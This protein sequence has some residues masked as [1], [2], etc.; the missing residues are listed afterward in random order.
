MRVRL[1]RLPMPGARRMEPPRHEGVIRVGRRGLGYAE[2]GDASGRLVLWH[3]GTP[4]GRRQIPLSA[5]RT[6][7]RL[8]LRLVCVE[9]P[10]VGDSTDHRYRWVR[11]GGRRHGSGRPARARSLCDGR[12]FGRRPVRARMRRYQLP[13]RV[14]AVGLLGSVCPVVGANRA[15]GSSIVGLAATFQG[16]LDPL[17]SVLGTGIW[18]AMQPIL[19]LG[20]PALRLYAFAACR[21]VTRRSLP[22]PTWR[23]CSSTTLPTR[24]AGGSAPSCTTLRCSGVR[25]ASSSGTSGRRCS[26][27]MATPTM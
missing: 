18:L 4:G 7:E 24:V 15:P 16:I 20:H 12:P 26:G 9:R 27:G 5:R 3:H 6:A 23:R 21:T 22:I 25:G 13:D 2:Y 19:P 10:G 1:P 11:D 14:V 8:G 17:R